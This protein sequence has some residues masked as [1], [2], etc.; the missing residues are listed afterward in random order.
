MQ[1]LSS[2][3]FVSDAKL[4]HELIE[5]ECPVTKQPLG[6]S[7]VPDQ[8]KCHSCGG[9]L[10][11]RKDRPSKMTLYTES[12]GTVPATHFHKYCQNFRKGCKFVQFYGYYR[13]DDGK[14]YYDDYWNSLPYFLSTQETGFEMAMLKQFDI[15]LLIGQMPYKQKAD[16]IYNITKGYDTTKK[17][18]STVEKDKEVHKPIHGYVH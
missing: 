3:S 10:L 9:K 12:L 5:M 11:L 7:L 4:T 18:C 13:S 17:V 1:V 6:I 8:I 15:E 2:E 14:L 16:I